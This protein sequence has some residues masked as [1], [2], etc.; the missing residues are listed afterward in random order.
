MK[1]YKLI[2]VI[3]L[4]LLSLNLFSQTLEER[5]KQIVSRN[6]IATKI[7]Y[8][9][10]YENGKA[11]KNGQKTS[12]TSYSKK[13]NILGKKYLTPKGG[14][15]SWEKYEYDADGNRTLYERENSN[16]KYKKESSYNDNSQAI[17][18][19]GFSGEEIFRTTYSYAITGKPLK[20]VRY[21]NNDMEEKLLY[22]HS[23][24][25]ALVDIYT[26]GSLVSSKLELIYDNRGNILEETVLSIDNRE[27]EKKTFTYNSASKLTMEAKTRAGNFYYKI[28]HIYDAKG[29]L[30]K[31]Y[32]ET[33]TKKKY[34]KKEFIFDSDNNL[35]TFKWR[36]GPNND[37]NV[38]KYTY[39]TKGIY[40]TEQ[41]FYP[42]T[43]YKSMAKFHYTFY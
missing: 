3:L 22:K 32:E 33:M 42:K 37:F 43:K 16:S 26:R 36:R 29:N 1:S 34:L 35:A 5:E 13:G 10:K 31:V 41:T 24:N 14:V 18:E 30:I 7:Q 21:V 6:N 8:N 12:I 19:A 4:F 2:P 27:L 17:L 39:N 20:I 15:S 40:L 28:S 23:G 25:H 11:V 9:H 38:K